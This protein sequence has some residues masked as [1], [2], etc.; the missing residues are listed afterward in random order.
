MR[1]Y[2]DVF[3][4]DKHIGTGVVTYSF[5]DNLVKQELYLTDFDDVPL[6]PGIYQIKFHNNAE[7]AFN[8]NS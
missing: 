5:N 2:F 8:G 6:P 3:E 1:L 4:E 7:I